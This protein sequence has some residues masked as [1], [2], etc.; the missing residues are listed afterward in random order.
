MIFGTY[1]KVYKTSE[2]SAGG[3]HNMSEVV[4]KTDNKIPPATP[5][6]F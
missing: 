2:K 3:I 6:E 4:Y 5:C 1:L